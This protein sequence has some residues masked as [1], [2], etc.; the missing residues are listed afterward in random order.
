MS[1]KDISADDTDLCIL[2]FHSLVGLDKA[3]SIILFSYF[4][5]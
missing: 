1:S 2:I 4:L 5:I 3:V